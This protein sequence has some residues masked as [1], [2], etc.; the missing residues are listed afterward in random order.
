MK[1]FLFTISL[2]AALSNIAFAGGTASVGGQCPGGGSVCPPANDGTLYGQ[3]E[4]GTPNTVYEFECE[5][6]SKPISQYNWRDQ[7][8]LRQV[9]ATN[10]ALEK[11]GMSYDPKTNRI[12]CFKKIS[13]S[14]DY[15]FDNGGRVI[16]CLTAPFNY[17]NVQNVDLTND[18]K[19]NRGIAD[20]NAYPVVDGTTGGSVLRQTNLKY[21]NKVGGYV[22]LDKQVGIM[23]GANFV[24]G[25]YAATANSVL[26]YSNTNY[27][28]ASTSYKKEAGFG[29]NSSKQTIS[30]PPQLKPKDIIFARLYWAGNIHSGKFP[31]K[32]L[33]GTVSNSSLNQKGKNIIKDKIAG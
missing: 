32:G 28:S 24:N 8:N 22:K 25:D 12:K 16:Q 18:C 26:N 33:I 4:L 11:K 23:Q 6:W 9:I 27:D 19:R 5:W 31:D 13:R 21:E 2:I 1:K 30:L 20:N 10:G 29:F 15:P 14:R 7:E 3:A 17:I